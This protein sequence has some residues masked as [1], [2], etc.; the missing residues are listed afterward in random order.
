EAL[1]QVVAMGVLEGTTQ[2]MN[3]LDVVLQGLRE[4]AQGK[5]T[6]LYHLDDT[7]VRITRLIEAPRDLVWRAMHEPE[8]VRRWMLGP[9]GWT[10]PVCEPSAVAGE[11]Y[12]YGWEPTGGTEGE[13]F[14]FEGDVLVV[15]APRRTVTTERMTGTEGPSTINDTVLAEEE[16]A[17][18][19]T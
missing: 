7:H 17:T 18:L 19:I 11:S 4:Y 6:V 5:G 8:L 14:G 16:G 13:A 1:E 15:N 9:D 3:Q 12:R 2:A 10:M